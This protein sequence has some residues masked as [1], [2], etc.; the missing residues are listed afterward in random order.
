VS[1]TSSNAELETSRRALSTEQRTVAGDREQPWAQV[2]GF[3]PRA[4][5]AERAHERL[6]QDV[7]RLFVGAQQVPA[8]GHQRGRMALVEELE[9]ALV[10]RSSEDR[11]AL[12]GQAGVGHG[13]PTRPGSD[14]EVRIMRIR[15]ASALDDESSATTRLR[16][17]KERCPE[18]LVSM[19]MHWLGGFRC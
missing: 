1:I 19:R 11:E 16:P 2:L 3:G 18:A 17:R 6:L 10:T 5:G 7:L 9:R 4:Q 15:G 8:E 14:P 13:S 12:V